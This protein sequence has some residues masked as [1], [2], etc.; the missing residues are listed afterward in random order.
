MQDQWV[1]HEGEIL[2]YCDLADLIKREQ[3]YIDFLNPEYNICKTAG[4]PMMGR[5]HSEETLA[6]MKERK[7]TEETRAKIS[8][9][10]AGQKLSEE[11]RAKMSSSKAGEKHPM[12]GKYKPRPEGAGR[13]YQKIEVIDIKNNITTIYDSISAAALALNIGKRFLS[14]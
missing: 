12:F 7:H 14:I 11:S 3:Y 13:P 6:K 4:A 10:K 9:S 2:E 8:S 5:K 1:L